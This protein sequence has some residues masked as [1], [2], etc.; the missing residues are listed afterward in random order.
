MY[1][2]G[3]ELIASSSVEKNLGVPVDKK[4][5]MSQNCVHA[6][7]KASNTLGCINRGAAAGREMGLSSCSAHMRN[8]L[9]YCIQAQGPQHK[10][11]TELVEHIQRRAM[12][13]NEM[14]STSLMTKG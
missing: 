10:K 8:L 6:V 11:D 3:E 7:R 2:V 4:L 12:R 9:P 5:D 1:R 13:M 14:R